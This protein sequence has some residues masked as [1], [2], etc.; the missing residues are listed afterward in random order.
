VDAIRH[1]THPGQLHTRYRFDLCRPCW[2]WAQALVAFSSRKCWDVIAALC[3][4]VC[5]VKSA[6]WSQQ[7][8]YTGWPLVSISEA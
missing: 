4:H 5:A 6:W 2:L 8:V 7:H 1:R 3:A